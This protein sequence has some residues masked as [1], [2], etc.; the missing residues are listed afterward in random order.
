MISLGSI[1]LRKQEIHTFPHEAL[2]EC[3]GCLESRRLACCS[4]GARSGPDKGWA[5]ARSRPETVGLYGRKGNQKRQSRE[6]DE[7]PGDK[8]SQKLAEQTEK[9]DKKR[10]RKH[11][12]LTVHQATVF[13]SFT[14]PG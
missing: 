4:S 5:G 3:S 11:K 12:D 10:E 7:S 14:A 9:K 13:Y 6:E 1:N 8:C 2:Q